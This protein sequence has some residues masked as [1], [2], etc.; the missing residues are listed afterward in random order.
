MNDF[1]NK[2][3]NVQVQIIVLLFFKGKLTFKKIFNLLYSFASY[4]FKASRS[5]KYP[6]MMNF[7]LWN[8]CNESCVFCRSAEGIITDPSLP[9]RVISKGKININLFKKLVNESSEYLILSVPYINGEPLL[10]KN[11]YECIKYSSEKN[12]GSLIATNGIILNEKNIHQ[13]IDSDIDLIKIHIS[14]MTNEI[15]NIEHRKGKVDQILENIKKLVEI[16]KI[17]NHRSIIM[18]D[19]ILYEHNKHQLNDAKQFA[20]NFGL[21]F[22]IRPGVNTGLEHIEKSHQLDLKSLSGKSCVWPYTILTIDWDG[23]LY[24]CCDH[25]SFT[26]AEAYEIWSNNFESKKLADLW[27]GE[28][29]KTMRNTLSKK[30]RKAILICSQCP[31]GGVGFKY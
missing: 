18:L 25:V 16:K 26:R 9:D 20:K 14:G 29:V 17:R 19:Y 1:F 6:I 10:S 30:G 12:I 31:R 24:P 2:Y 23:S 27:N 13:L 28:R 3:L 5:G 4:F 8:E 21:V 22:N 11:I 15:H 7:E